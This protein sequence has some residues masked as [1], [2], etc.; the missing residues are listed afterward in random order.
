MCLQWCHVRRI[1]IDNDVSC[2]G[3]CALAR[4]LPADWSCATCRHHVV[5]AGHRGED[6]ES[7]KG[8]CGLTHL[9]LPRQGAC[10]HYS[11]ELT[12]GD[13]PLWLGPD[14][15]APTVGVRTASRTAAE[16]FAQSD[17]APEV[18]RDAAGRVRVPVKALAVP[19][20]YGLPSDAWPEQVPADDRRAV[21]LALVDDV[22]RLLDLVA[23]GQ[24][25]DAE[26]WSLKLQAL[27]G[28]FDRYPSPWGHYAC[29]ATSLAEQ[30]GR[31]TC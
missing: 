10:C 16:A 5:R 25:A 23:G 15:L 18:E 3:F 12:P 6:G 14:Q 13:E 4:S 24:Y 21:S 28:P 2:A 11:V 7:R 17:T 1:L 27:H 8:L 20:V 26:H 31:S 22:L 30:A 9:D 29:D 19:D